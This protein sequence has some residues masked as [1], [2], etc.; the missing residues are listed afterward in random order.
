MA[1]KHKKKSSP[2]AAPSAPAQPPPPASVK[3]SLTGWKLWRFR[4]L[5]AFG[6]P[7][8]LLLLVELGLRASGYG[9]PTKFLLPFT[10][11]GRN[12]LVQNNEFGW[13][14]FGPKMA[15][16]PGPSAF[17]PAKPPN[18]VR[19][20]VFGESAAYGDPNPAFGL[21][22]M[23][24]AMLELRYPGVKFEVI[25]AAM[26]GI[27]SNVIL[28]I[29]RDCAAANGDIW[30]V[31]MGNNEVV[32]PFGAGTVFGSQAPPLWLIRASLAIKSSR[33]G[34]LL[35]SIHRKLNK[36]PPDKSEW[37]GM[38]MFLDQQV[39]AADPRMNAVYRNFQRNLA[40]IIRAGRRGGAGVVVS[41]VASNLKDSAPFGSAH[42]P[43][44]AAADLE[45]WKQHYTNGLAALAT[46][47][48]TEAAASFREAARLDD[49]F[50][51][52]R[53]CQ[54]VCALA[55]GDGP[56]ARQN[57]TAA[58]DLDTLRFRCD[59][60]LNELIRATATNRES[61]R[62]L[63]ADSDAAFAQQSPDG[64]P[65]ADL[66]YEHVHLTFAGN[67]L[68][69]RTLLGQ[70]EKLLPQDV[71]A[72][73]A[74]SGAWPTE[75]DC[76]K[77]LAWSKWSQQ[78]IWQDILSRLADPPFNAQFT[79]AA[80]VA[81]VNARLQETAGTTPL[82]NVTDARKICEAALAG[83]PDDP[84]LL[85]QLASLKSLA[86]DLPGAEKDD[87]RVVELL[88]ASTDDWFQ[89]GLALGRQGKLEESITA[90][91]RAFELNPENVWA[92]QNLAHGLLSA[93][94]R[95]EAIKEFRRAVAIKPRFGLAWIGLGEA[96]EAAGRKDEAR[97]CFAEGIAN[98]IPRTPE[99]LTMAHF[100]VNR[101]LTV[102]A[103][104]FYDQALNLSPADT[105]LQ[106]E[107]ARAHYNYGVELGRKGDAQAAVIEFRE[108]V[109][110]MP[111][112]TEA[113]VN[114]GI[115]LESQGLYNEA[116]AAY[117]EAVKRDP[118]NPLPQ[119]HLKEVRKNLRM[120][121]TP[122]S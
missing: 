4:L 30:V 93:G 67:Y 50:A 98:P 10:Q 111:D 1:R 42:R 28:P 14:F 36:P 32:G 112:S 6:I 88:P 13:R 92:L 86:G 60:R 81:R 109:R 113:R 96:L 34:E 95:D 18:T 62:V 75:A 57:F 77:R 91:R 19:I 24:Q 21:P 45:K 66:F 33:L 73:A 48:F 56:A 38:T 11:N 5:A 82:A 108:V 83:A 74:T 59:S 53:F 51:E 16:L 68:L 49:S 43:D 58:R 80:Q 97:Q 72:R 15:R 20:F 121:I 61:E 22:R 54:G 104:E 94:R 17:E 65:G 2:A 117:S 35:D 9:Y 116:D 40:D 120:T 107:V 3:P 90:S 122:G 8:L 46:N 103:L 115:A 100:C 64:L 118:N 99:L 119:Q 76:A 41:T 69:A 79:H 110:L 71:A 84:I 39:T 44:L 101:G 23:L 47:N 85:Q 12:L 31:Y 29:A 70:V 26:T 102:Q 89:L 52:L 114:L 55:L 7:V 25:N 87:R 105:D 63:L 106:K 37:G 78:S 27:N